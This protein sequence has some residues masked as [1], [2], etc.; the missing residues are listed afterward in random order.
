MTF[1]GI[2]ENPSAYRMWQNFVRHFVA[3]LKIQVPN[4]VMK[5]DKDCYNWKVMKL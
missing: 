4:F 5:Q 3:F 2:F 1:C